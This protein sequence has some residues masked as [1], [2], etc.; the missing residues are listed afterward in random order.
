MALDVNQIL[1]KLL[2]AMK[3]ILGQQWGAVEK[4]S[5]EELTKMGQSLAKIE[6]KKLTGAITEQQA[7][8]LF[9]MQR[10][11]FKAVIAAVQGVGEQAAAKALDA[12]LAAIKKDV[13]TALGLEL[14]K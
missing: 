9:E 12:G 13:N 10:N 3:P 5:K 11:S 1:Q 8:I 14:I 2:D 4:Y 7:A 6:A